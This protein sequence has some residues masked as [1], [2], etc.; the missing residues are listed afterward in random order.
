MWTSVKLKASS[1]EFHK[2]NIAN[3]QWHEMRNRKQ[4][5]R[6]YCKFE[7]FQFSVIYLIAR[8]DDLND[9]IAVLSLTRKGISD[10]IIKSQYYYFPKIKPI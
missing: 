10:D 6:D 7:I 4:F 9:V 5:L 8:K 3:T 2:Y 1:A